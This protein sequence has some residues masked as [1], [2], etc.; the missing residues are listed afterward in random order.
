MFLVS[1]RLKKARASHQRMVEE[2]A[3][4]RIGNKEQ[5]ERGD[6]MTYFMRPRGQR[7]GLS[8]ADLVANT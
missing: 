1:D 7:H 2:L 8:D 4:K 5:E 6:F 3:M